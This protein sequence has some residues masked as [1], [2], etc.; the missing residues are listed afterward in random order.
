MAT[1]V[2]LHIGAPKSGSTYL[3]GVLHTNHGA[4]ADAGLL[5]PGEHADHF[6]LMMRAT[7]RDAELPRS[8]AGERTWDRVFAEI[9][10]WLGSAVVSHEMLCIA[11]AEQARTVIDAVEPAEAHVVY[12][13]RDLART[14]PSEWQQAV[15]GGLT[16]RFD[17]YVSAVRDGAA[18]AAPFASMHDV[19]AVLARWGR[20]L[21]P[22]QV[23]VVTV[24]QAGSD[25]DVLWARFAQVV[26]VP[27]EAASA[28][29]QRAN[30]SL[31]AVEAELLRRVNVAVRGVMDPDDPRLV[32]WLRRNVALNLLA[33]R[34][35]QQRFALRPADFDWVVDRAQ[36]TGAALA[37]SGYDIVGD[38]SEL[39][40]AV[41]PADGPQP[42]DVRPDDLAAAA[43]DTIAGLAATLREA[44][45]GPAASTAPRAE[46]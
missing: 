26:G 3:Q 25:P 8:K 16:L 4:L 21:D 31:G 23:H 42:D 30:E 32:P 34:T 22:K 40:P 9:S 15:R 11:S 35:G 29:G 20:R 2:Y 28:R 14:L 18:D 39:V 43:I 33:R 1:A 44:Q 10:N 36:R 5:V 45:G 7:G 41:V 13:V 46:G 24:P 37:A 17:D 27:P 12:T 19:P 38:L 6:R